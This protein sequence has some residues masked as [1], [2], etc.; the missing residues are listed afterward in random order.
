[1][2]DEET[3]ENE[4]SNDDSEQSQRQNSRSVDSEQLSEQI[5]GGQEVTDVRDAPKGGYTM[6]PSRS[7]TDRG[8]GED[9]TESDGG[10]SEDSDS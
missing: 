1:M 10:N 3:G 9:G 4:S 8:G 2:S 7:D 6:A 5:E